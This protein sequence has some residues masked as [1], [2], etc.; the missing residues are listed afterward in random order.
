MSTTIDYN[1]D[2]L[3][4]MRRVAAVLNQVLTAADSG[5]VEPRIWF[6]YDEFVRDLATLSIVYG[7][8]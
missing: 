1:A 4:A 6:H 5:E 2:E 8:N 7:R 3:A